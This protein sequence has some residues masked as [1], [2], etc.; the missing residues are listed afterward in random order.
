M[1]VNE[2]KIKWNFLRMCQV[3][4]IGF[5]IFHVGLRLLLVSILQ[6][7]FLGPILLKCLIHFVFE[8]VIFLCLWVLHFLENKL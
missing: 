2:A 5:K 6:V 1:H 7:N 3:Y 4:N 8:F